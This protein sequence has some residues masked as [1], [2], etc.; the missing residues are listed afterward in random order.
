MYNQML[1]DLISN[2]FA[3]NHANILDLLK[4]YEL[5]KF[6]S[7]FS[8]KIDTLKSYNVQK[9]TIGALTSSLLT[10]INIV[11]EK[12][13]SNEDKAQLEYILSEIS[14][15]FTYQ[16][17]QKE[18]VSQEQVLTEIKESLITTCEINNW[19]IELLLKRIKI[20]LRHTLL[21]KS[22]NNILL[23][24]SENNHSKIYYY[25][26]LGGEEHLKEFTYDLKDKKIIKSV[27]EFK[28]LFNKHTGKIQ[29]RMSS[30]HI[31]FIVLLF[32]QM[33]KENLIRPCGTKG[34]FFPLKVYCV[35]FDKKVLFK[36]EPKR[37][38]EL[39]KRDSTK[40]AKLLEEIGVLIGK[41]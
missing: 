29:I 25:E 13:K 22:E 15:E 32:D 30:S 20:D 24:K 3:N 33:K 26:W 36:K 7:D 10:R 17:L 35:D 2:L 6:I 27:E 11:L 4:K 37:I 39:I 1:K 34:H 8:E 40:H 9:N 16:L 31:D 21:I 19:D 18:G 41:R 23:K 14:N 38:K 5:Y 28:K 12:I